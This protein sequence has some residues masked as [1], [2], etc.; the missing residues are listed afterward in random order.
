MSICIG[1]QQAPFTLAGGSRGKASAPEYVVIS[2]TS[3]LEE[4]L[5]CGAGQDRSAVVVTTTRLTVH[6]RDR[7][8][9]ACRD[10]G[11][12]PPVQGGG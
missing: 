6:R 3:F 7:V 8:N 2:C 9:G 1:T 10:F 11:P 5:P 4:F 12:N